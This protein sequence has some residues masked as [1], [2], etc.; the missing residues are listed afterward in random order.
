MSKKI[1]TKKTKAL[2]L[3]SLF[4]IVGIII[5][6]LII[7]QSKVIP[8]RVTD[9]ISPYLSLK[10]TKDLLYTEQADLK[11]EVADLQKKINEITGSTAS[12]SDLA[13]LNYK[14]AQ[15]GL[16]KLNGPGIIATIDDSKDA[17]VSEESIVHA[18]DLRDIVNLLWGSTAEGIAINGERV[19]GTTSIDCIVNTVL[20]ND[21]R[22][23]NPFSIEAIGSIETMSQRLN[24]QNIL[25]DIHRRANDLGLIFR[26]EINSDITLPAYSGA[27]IK[28]TG[29]GNV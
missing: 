14:R 25:T 1:D 18:A 22:I 28:T 16:T 4:A 23:S 12:S 6:M 9:S 21:T 17:P 2:A 29:G 7:L 11:A 3:R 10:D 5:G 15:A 8:T 20:I 13:N 19:I 26:V 24:D 27:L